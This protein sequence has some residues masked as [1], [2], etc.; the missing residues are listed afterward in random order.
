MSP[1]RRAS[2]TVSNLRSAVTAGGPQAAPPPI[3][4]DPKEEAAAPDPALRPEPAAALA[5]D[6]APATA[7]PVRRRG[8]KPRPPKPI[9]FTLDLNQDRHSF[10]KRFA[11]EAEV[12]AALVMRMLLDQLRSDEDLAERVR[13]AAW[14]A[15]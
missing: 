6:P 3:A 8:P 9:R 1:T 10:L 13:Q 12:D 5:P 2:S 11:L 7:A 14:E 15:E 4:P